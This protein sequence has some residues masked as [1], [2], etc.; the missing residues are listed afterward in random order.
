MPVF[1]RLIALFARMLAVSACSVPNR[2]GSSP[3]EVS[4]AAYRHD[5]P[6]RLTLYT[7]ISNTSGS[8]AHTSLMISGSQRIAFDPAG[9]FR[10]DGVA[11]RDDVVYGMTPYLADVY[12]RFHARKSYHVV[13]QHLDVSPEVAERAL[14]IALN[15]GPVQQ[16]YCAKSTS[17]LLSQLP[18]FEDIHQTYYPRKLMDSFATKGAS[19]DRLYEYD[20]DDKSKVLKAF[21]PE[22]ELKKKK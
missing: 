20:D 7:M 11:T 22:Y 14:Q 8:G 13:V 16:A 12:T 6:P 10:P 2:G 15:Y 4:K 9:S 18:G 21:V 17:D 19:Y 3:E 1:M 5:G